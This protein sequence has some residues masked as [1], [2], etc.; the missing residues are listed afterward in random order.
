MAHKNPT[1]I[2]RDANSHQKHA[3]IIALL[4]ASSADGEAEG[5]DLKDKLQSL[6]KVLRL[7]LHNITAIVQTGI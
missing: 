2:R 6:M 5:A 1:L 7:T 3:F 4:K